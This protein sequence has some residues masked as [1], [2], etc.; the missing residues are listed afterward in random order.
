MLLEKYLDHFAKALLLI[1]LICGGTQAVT[2]QSITKATAS[3]RTEQMGKIAQANAPKM[4]ISSIPLLASQAAS[5]KIWKDTATGLIWTMKD[6]GS[7]VNWTQARDY[8]ESLSLGGY[9]DW[10]LPTI[11]ELSAIYDGSLSKPYKTKGPIEL[12]ASGVWSATT[13]DSGDVWSFYFSYGGRSPGP[14]RGHGGSGRAL[15]V[16]GSGA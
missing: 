14:I 16:R 1:T 5:N 6:S 10:R 11:D 3:G 7:D 2:G 4:Q 13:N 8:C 12:G 9:S 15:C